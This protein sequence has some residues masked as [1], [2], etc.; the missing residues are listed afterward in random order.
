MFD[1]F[2]SFLLSV[3]VVIALLVSGY[4]CSAWAEPLDRD[5]KHD[6]GNLQHQH[7]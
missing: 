4:V 1:L 6:H 3:G 2:V 5:A 7:R